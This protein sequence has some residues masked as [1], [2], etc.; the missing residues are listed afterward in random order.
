MGQ[1]L[2]ITVHAFDEDIAK[3]FIIGLHIPQAL[4]R[5]QKTLSI[6]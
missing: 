4:F 2:V 6:M 5:K 3:I 1:R